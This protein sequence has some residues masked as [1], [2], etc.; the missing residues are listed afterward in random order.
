MHIQCTSIPPSKTNRAAGANRRP[1]EIQTN[2][3][4]PQYAVSRARSGKEAM[5]R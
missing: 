1:E 2:Y 5:D 3:F 4:Q